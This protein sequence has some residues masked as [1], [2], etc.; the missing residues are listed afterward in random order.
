MN[1]LI[2]INSVSCYETFQENIDFKGAMIVI[3]EV[4]GLTDHIKSVADRFANE[5]YYVIAPDLLS[6]TEIASFDTTSLQSDLFNP[7]KRNEVQPK[8]RKLMTPL[9]APDFADKTN[10]KLLDVFEFIYQKDEINKKIGVVGFCFGGTYSYNLSILEPRLKLAIPFYGHCDNLVDD[11][12]KI[13][14][15]ILAFYGQ[16]DEGLMSG[17]DNL[18]DRMS[19]AG[20]NYISKVYQNCGHAFF[21]NSNPFAYNV[22]AASNAWQLVNDFLVDNM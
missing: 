1:R 15:P 10:Q 18:K 16:N 17:L 20:V 2:N 14:C 22:D 9:H 12:K 5:G 11:L 19:E 4:W 7:E 3:H 8:L 6:E 21:N 13:K